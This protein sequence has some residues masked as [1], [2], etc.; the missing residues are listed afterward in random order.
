M[1]GTR[2]AIMDGSTRNPA[3]LDLQAE[4]EVMDRGFEALE[5]VT[6]Q[7]PIG[8][9]SAAWDFSLNTLDFLERVRSHVLFELHGQ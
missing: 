9:R 4:R 2:S 5:H 8:Y 6:G 3:N 7:R 1:K